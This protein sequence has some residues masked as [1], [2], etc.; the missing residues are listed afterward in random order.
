[1]LEQ[2]KI[3]QI[4]CLEGLKQLE[5]DSIDLLLTD[6]PYDFINRKTNGLRNLDKDKADI[7][8]FNLNEFMKEI[9]RVVKGSY[10]I[11]CGPTQVSEIVAFFKENKTSVRQL[12][13]EKTN[14]SPMNGQHL[15]LSS[16]ENCVF[17]KKRNATFKEHCKS[18]VI[19]HKNGR[20]KIHPTEKPLGLFEYLITVSTNEGDLVLDTCAGS[21]T[22]AIACLKN[23]RRYICFEK[24]EQYCNL[25]INRINGFIYE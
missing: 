20:S 7:L 21:G 6:I 5:S 12:I 10:Y 23:N 9:L 16:V 19:R 25:A 17:A 4:D 8:T 14:P 13:W 2:N 22:T 3:Y 1:M 18:A 15:W 24:D 11:F